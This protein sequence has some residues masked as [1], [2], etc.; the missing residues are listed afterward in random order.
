[1]NGTAWSL[2]EVGHDRLGDDGDIGNAPAADGDRDR[3]PRQ[4]FVCQL[5][6]RELAF[7][8]LRN[9]VKAGTIEFLT[10]AEHSRKRHGAQ[11]SRRQFKVLFEY[12]ARKARKREAFL[13]V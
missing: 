11:S 6:R 8:F 10:Q 9:V 5:E 12:I 7:D 3:L 2:L 13:V 1:M 4:D